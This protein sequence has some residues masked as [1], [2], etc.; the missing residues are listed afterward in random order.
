MATGQHEVWSGRVPT[1]Q[2]LADKAGWAKQQRRAEGRGHRG[3]LAAAQ[4]P[5]PRRPRLS[6]RESKCMSAQIRPGLDADCNPPSSLLL[7]DAFLCV[8]RFAFCVSRARQ[9]GCEGGGRGGGGGGG[10]KVVE[11]VAVQHT[12]CHAT[13][14]VLSTWYVLCRVWCQAHRIRLGGRRFCRCGFHRAS[15]VY[16]IH[17]PSGT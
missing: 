1:A 7:R 15:Q 13:Y 16:A 6:Q 2:G 8:L 17:T 11:A 5:R 4:G 14:I 10:A 3:L 9:R 12:T